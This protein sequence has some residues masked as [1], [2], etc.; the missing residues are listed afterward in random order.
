VG[1]IVNI[2]TFNTGSDTALRNCE[3][4]INISGDIIQLQVKG[5]ASTTITWVGGFKVKANV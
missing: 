5:I 1:S 3:A 4:R 2:L